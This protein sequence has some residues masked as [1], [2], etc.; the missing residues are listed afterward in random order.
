MSKKV[1]PSF[2][3]SFNVLSA[4]NETSYMNKNNVKEHIE[5]YFAVDLELLNNIDKL[6]KILKIYDYIDYSK[7]DDI[8]HKKVISDYINELNEENLFIETVCLVTPRETGDDV[9][10]EKGISADKSCVSLTFIIH[11]NEKDVFGKF[12]RK[13]IYYQDKKRKYNIW[14]ITETNVLENYLT[15]VYMLEVLRIR[16]CLDIRAQLKKKKIKTTL[17]IYKY[18]S[19]PLL[20]MLRFIPLQFSRTDLKLLIVKK[21]K[22]Y[23]GLVKNPLRDYIYINIMSKI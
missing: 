16:I 21:D 2:S 3:S 15:L 11:D 18:N 12:F 13:P 23:N 20:R 9:E 22:F 10:L 8:I 5:F 17:N 19:L 7:K 14:A 4:L 1:I 6:D